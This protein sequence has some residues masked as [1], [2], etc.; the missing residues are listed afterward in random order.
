MEK[1]FKL[2]KINDKNSIL[3]TLKYCSSCL[4]NQNI[5]NDSSLKYYADKFCQNAHVVQ[6]CCDNNVIGFA[7]YY[8]N[9]LDNKNAFLSMIIILSQYQSM[10]AGSALLKYILEDCKSAGMEHLL[11]EVDKQNR[12]AIEFYLKKGFVFLDKEN[13]KSFFMSLIIS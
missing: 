8:C 3:R 10:G 7:S 9:D 12:S 6:I 13:D 1:H 4:F 2:K 5:N 11:L